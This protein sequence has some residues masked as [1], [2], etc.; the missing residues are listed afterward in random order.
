[1]AQGQALVLQYSGID[2]VLPVAWTTRNSPR[3]RTQPLLKLPALRS[4]ATLPSC[5]PSLLSGHFSEVR[6]R[7]QVTILEE[8]PSAGQTVSGVQL[9]MLKFGQADGCDDNGSGN[10]ILP[11]MF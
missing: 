1:M 10:P 3:L 4:E 2:M 9:S 11:G 8:V 7:C 6:G 5:A